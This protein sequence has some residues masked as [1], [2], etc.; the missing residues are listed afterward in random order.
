MEKDCTR[1]HLSLKADYRRG[2]SNRLES[3]VSSVTE[4][5]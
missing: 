2:T 1:I 4:K 5:L 3:K